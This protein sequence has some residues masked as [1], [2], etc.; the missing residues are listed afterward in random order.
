MYIKCI[1]M[2]IIILLNVSKWISLVYQMYQNGSLSSVSNMYKWSIKV[3]QV[4]HMS[5]T[6]SF[7]FFIFVKENKFVLLA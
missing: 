3:Y 6:F 7:S 4:Y 1:K 2:N 5:W